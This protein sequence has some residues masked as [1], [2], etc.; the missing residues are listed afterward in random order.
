MIP[1]NDSSR[2]L[3]LLKLL[4]SNSRHVLNPGPTGTGK[5]INIFTLLTKELS[6]EY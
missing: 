3:Y 2:N 6:E 4:L 5:S 1:T